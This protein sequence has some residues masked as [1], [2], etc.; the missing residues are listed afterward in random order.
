MTFHMLKSYVWSEATKLGSRPH[1]P[2]LSLG[3][4]FRAMIRIQSPSP[5]YLLLSLLGLRKE[6][7]ASR[8]HFHGPVGSRPIDQFR[9][10][11]RRGCKVYPQPLLQ[12][13]QS[14]CRRM[15]QAAGCSRV[16]LEDPR[17]LFSKGPARHSVLSELKCF[18]TFQ[19]RE[20]ILLPVSRGF[21]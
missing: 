3:S 10:L 8:R 11:Y 20:T 18:P 16:S 7:L 12:S 4:R 21:L 15:R 9:E 2:R 13:F 1:S 14:L 17:V 5:E 19:A 6:A